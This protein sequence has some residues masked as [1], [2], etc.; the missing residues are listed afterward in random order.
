MPVVIFYG[1]LGSKKKG[2]IIVGGSETGNYRTISILEKAGYQVIK[3]RKPYHI[4]RSFWGEIHYLIV[5]LINHLLFPFKLIRIKGE[6]IVHLAGYY[7][8]V[9]YFEW[10]IITISSLLNCKTVYELRAGGLA[11]SLKNGSKLYKRFLKSTL[12]RSDKILTQGF[13]DIRILKSLTQTPVFYYP[14]YIKD[15]ILENNNVGVRSNST[16]IRITYFGRLAPSKNI[17]FIIDIAEILKRNGV[18]FELELIG[19]ADKKYS[20]S[21]SFNYVDSIKRII[22]D[23]NLSENIRITPPMNQN[24]LFELLRSK[25]FFIFP[26]NEKREGHSN[27]LTEAMSCG[28]VPIASNSGFN[29]SVVGMDELIFQDFNCEDYANKIIQIWNSGNWPIYSQRMFDRI[30]NNYTESIVSKNLIEAYR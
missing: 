23:K 6:K 26:S 3:F 28:L 5:L 19:N 1:P 14:N 12:N 11:D 17:S 27:S 22:K 21:N 20:R 18:N 30:K 29:R 4:A 25:H 9:I 16:T 2:E 15:D 10:F 7:V 8:N 24:E 13:D